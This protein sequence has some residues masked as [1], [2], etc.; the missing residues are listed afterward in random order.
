MFRWTFNFKCKWWW[1]WN[2]KNQPPLKPF[3]CA[4][5]SP[6][7]FCQFLRPRILDKDFFAWLLSISVINFSLNIHLTWMTHCAKY[8]CPWTHTVHL[9]RMN[10]HSAHW[11]DKWQ[12]ISALKCAKSNVI[13][14][15]IASN[16]FGRKCPLMLLVR[17]KTFKVGLVFIDLYHNEHFYSDWNLVLTAKAVI[18]G[19]WTKWGDQ[20]WP[21]GT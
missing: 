10:V 1:F 9:I 2:W 13:I 18:L 21:D 6:V 8:D 16:T 17:S 5:R 12:V 11:H 7:K 15:D 14:D 20:M 19:T 3:K 4:F